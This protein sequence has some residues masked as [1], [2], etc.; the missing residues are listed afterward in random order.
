MK[1]AALPE[2]GRT[3]TMSSMRKESS[4]MGE[5]STRQETFIVV[6]ILFVLRWSI[7]FFLSCFVVSL[8]SFGRSSSNVRRRRWIFRTLKSSH[9]HTSTIRY[10]IDWQYIYFFS[11][12]FTLFM[13][14]S[15]FFLLGY[16]D[17]HYRGDEITCDSC[18]VGVC[19][20]G[21]PERERAEE[22]GGRSSSVTQ[23]ETRVY[24]RNL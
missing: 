24:R 4:W 16:S 6:C 10:H 23:R 20:E 3:F 2:V 22:G 15:S 14:S 8:L 17:I 21:C 19:S 7:F 1:E 9:T 13:M 11:S 12:V 5:M 18:F